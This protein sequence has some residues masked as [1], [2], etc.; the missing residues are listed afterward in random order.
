[1]VIYEVNLAVDASIADD[2]AAW[3]A[4]HIEEVLAVDGFT[5]ADWWIVEPD[6]DSRQRDRVHW[7]VQYHVESRDALATYVRDHAE[8][9][10]GDGLARFGGRFE[11]SRRVLVP[12][13]A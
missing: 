1:M 7:C 11:A 2:Y 10:R 6:G 13:G 5:S 9:L 3:L 4:P 8:R 12:R